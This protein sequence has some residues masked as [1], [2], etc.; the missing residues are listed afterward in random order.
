[1]KEWQK[2]NFFF[3]YIKLFNFFVNGRYHMHKKKSTE[4]AK[5]FNFNYKKLLQ[6][7]EY[8]SLRKIIINFYQS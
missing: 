2:L 1:M 6:G 4:N 8:K 3:I 5:L 7:A